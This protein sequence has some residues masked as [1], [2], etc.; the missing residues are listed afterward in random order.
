[1]YCSVLPDVIVKGGDYRPEQVAGGDCVIN[2]GGEVK[3]LPF[4]EGQSST[5][6]I[7]R[8]REIFND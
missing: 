7:N 3:I 2:A 6:I 1:L 4:V 8:Y 5:S